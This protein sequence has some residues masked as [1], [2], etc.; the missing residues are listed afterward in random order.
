MRDLDSEEPLVPHE[1]GF[2]VAFGLDKPL[3]QTYGS[4]VA[5]TVTFNYVYKMESGQ[6]AKTGHLL[7]TYPAIMTDS[8]VSI[9]QRSICMAFQI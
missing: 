3:D 9:R 2:N 7:S 1:F 5:N 8:L 6:E 4:Y